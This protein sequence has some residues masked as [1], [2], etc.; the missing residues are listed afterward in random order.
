[1]LREWPLHDPRM[2]G[3]DGSSHGGD[4]R[5]RALLSCRLDLFSRQ[6]PTST[7]NTGTNTSDDRFIAVCW[8]RAIQLYHGRNGSGPVAEYASLPPE[9]EVGVDERQLWLRLWAMADGHAKTTEDHAVVRNDSADQHTDQG[10]ME[11]DEACKRLLGQFH[12][13]VQQ[14]QGSNGCSPHAQFLAARVTTAQDLRRLVANAQSRYARFFYL[15]LV[16]LSILVG[17]C[18]RLRRSRTT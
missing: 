9:T 3:T 18:W 10:G 17:S 12:A 14:C 4:C 13:L 7:N 6:H 1:M 16:L 15:R 2:P 11:S 5:V 8:P